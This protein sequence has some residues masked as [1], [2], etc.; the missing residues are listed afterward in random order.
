MR[1]LVLLLGVICFGWVATTQSSPG[2]PASPPR[3]AVLNLPTGS[4]L[5]GLLAAE[6]DAW[7]GV[8]LVVL[9]AEPW[10]RDAV[11]PRPTMHILESNPV[12]VLRLFSGRGDGRF[13]LA[14][15]GTLP[16][17]IE[18]ETR[19]YL[20]GG[21]ILIEPKWPI[22]M[23]APESLFFSNGNVIV[24]GVGWPLDRARSL[25]A[26]GENPVIG[27]ASSVTGE[28]WNQ[29]P[30]VLNNEV[31]GSTNDVRHLLLAQGDPLYAVAQSRQGPASLLVLMGD[32]VAVGDT[33]AYPLLVY[34]QTPDGLVEVQRLAVGERGVTPS[35]VATGDL[36]SDGCDDIVVG[37]AGPLADRIEIFL[38]CGDGTFQPAPRSV[39][40]SEREV[41]ALLIGDFDG[42]GHSDIIVLG[43]QQ[44]LLL[45]GNSRGEFN[46]GGTFAFGAPQTGRAQQA[47]VG[48]FNGDNWLDIALAQ[49]DRVLLLFG[50][51]GGGYRARHE[52]NPRTLTGSLSFSASHLVA[53]DLDGPRGTDLI[54]GSAATKEVAI[55]LSDGTGAFTAVANPVLGP[56]PGIVKATDMNRDG[57]D[58]LVMVYPS[59]R[60]L[61]VELTTPSPTAATGT[62]FT[63]LS[64]ASAAES[65]TITL[66]LDNI[67]YPSDAVIADFDGNGIFDIAVSCAVL[68]R[69]LII[70][71]LQSYGSSSYSRYSRA[72]LRTEV[73]SVGKKPVQLVLMNERGQLPRILALCTGSSNL[74]I[75]GY[76]QAARRIRLLTPG[77]IPVDSC[78]Y[79]PALLVGAAF[80]ADGDGISDVLFYH[81]ELRQLTWVSG[82]SSFRTAYR[83][84]G[85]RGVV[86][87]L[88]TANLNSDEIPDLVAAVDESGKWFLQLW[89]GTREGMCCGR[90]ES[91]YRI[92]Q[93]SSIPLHSRPVAMLVQDL[94]A[95]K[96]SDIAVA[97]E[98]EPWVRIW[99]G[100]GDW[101][102]SEVQEMTWYNLAGGRSSA[103]PLTGLLA[104]NVR[105]GQQIN[106]YLVGFAEQHDE[107]LFVSLCP[108]PP[109]PPDDGRVPQQAVDLAVGDFDGDGFQELAVLVPPETTK[110]S[111]KILILV[112][113]RS[114]GGTWQH[115][116]TP[117]TV[118]GPLGPTV[119]IRAAD[120]NM[121]RQTDLI[122]L[123]VV[124][125]RLLILWGSAFA[126]QDVLGPLDPG[127]SALTAGTSAE[128]AWILAGST[129]FFKSSTSEVWNRTTLHLGGGY[130]QAA[131]T[132]TSFTGG[133]SP[134]LVLLVYYVAVNRWTMICYDGERLVRGDPAPTEVC[135]LVDVMG[136]Q[137]LPIP[138]LKTYR[139]TVSP[140]VVIDRLKQLYP[141]AQD[142]IGVGLGDVNSDGDLDLVTLRVSGTQTRISVAYGPVG[143]SLGAWGDPFLTCGTDVNQAL[144]LADLM[145]DG[146]LDVVVFNPA[147]GCI[148]IVYNTDGPI[149]NITISGLT[150][151]Q[152]RR[153]F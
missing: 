45:I 106:A 7:P 124:N 104:L 149:G 14:S 96:R 9:T 63:A 69:V 116:T 136:T 88:A 132:V 17:Y 133:P 25:A 94:N 1:N 54:V 79:C 140:T 12:G 74:Y 58:D 92:L 3:R 35:V 122:A 76:D 31:F 68:N 5:I 18:T 60:Q 75:L 111:W 37:F 86:A 16:L 121:D 6:I 105:V 55:L 29:P 146:R 78:S 108:S 113:P 117:L 82:N 42:Y 102:L 26:G 19:T 20:E 66:P 95:D 153:R 65:S 135:D 24:P 30:Q 4:T 115:R 103:Q 57:A 130:A 84:T 71:D 50:E 72:V 39:R 44:S 2:T 77:G 141:A 98:G 143:R 152:L 147:K 126:R 148:A 23:R 112:P 137:P 125:N 34:H 41:R 46:K 134:D 38:N 123:D 138:A 118:Q 62:P 85:P 15:G 10:P 109:P 91:E 33:P 40:V 129:L 150:I 61:V 49:G 22:A 114:S 21:R 90:A 53:V 8:D 64:P 101:A 28:I 47:A 51:Q 56:G 93:E 119:S 11:S 97:F 67:L 27:F 128:G 89:R 59:T 32:L 139:G 36:N 151:L 107:R 70:Y 100:R 73:L 48:Y 131:W 145:G 142:P 52:I 120:L 80:D 81:R 127:T 43:P 99:L 110:E 87:L 13:N 144:L 83:L